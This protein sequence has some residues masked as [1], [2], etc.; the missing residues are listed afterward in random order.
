MKDETLLQVDEDGLP[1]G[2]AKWAN[3]KL[4]NDIGSMTIAY[5]EDAWRAALQPGNSA[6]PVTVPDGYV[7]VPVELLSD[8]RDFAHPEIEKY[9]EM[10]EGR[11]DA[12]FPAMRKIISD[13]DALLSAAPQSPGSQLTTTPGWTDNSDANAALVMLDR[14]DTLDPADDDRIEE[15]KRI[16]RSLAEPTAP[17]SW[18]PVSERM[19]LTPFDGCEYS[20]IE[21][22][23]FDGEHVFTAHYAVGS[24]PQPW[25][26]WVD[27]NANITHW[28]PLP[29]APKVKP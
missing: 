11:R 2:F 1:I 29:D 7:L 21:V 26:D 19:P 12:E 24:L 5:C 18:I 22:S 20:D 4:P 23:A 27:T 17:D 6:Q 16:I 25:G 3:K 13:A 8:L 10:W 28:Q 15:V 14:I 9:C